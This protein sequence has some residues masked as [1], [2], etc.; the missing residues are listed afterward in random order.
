MK[1]KRKKAPYPR[2]VKKRALFV[3]GWV[4]GTGLDEP[5]HA[6]FT[7]VFDT[8]EEAIKCGRTDVGWTDG[9]TFQTGYL[10]NEMMA[11]PN[12]LDAENACDRAEN[13]EFGEAMME[14]W[15]DKVFPDKTKRQRAPLD[16]LQRKLDVLW[17]EWTRRHDLYVRGFWID[18][19][20]RHAF[21][22]PA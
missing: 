14:T 20:E 17:E 3:D 22:E 12:Q 18:D 2:K 19:V 6:T 15:R 4:C 16:D 10:R 11:M 1:R 7:D 13:E 21:K 8:R 9:D 5:E